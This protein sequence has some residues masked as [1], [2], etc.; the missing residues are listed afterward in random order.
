[1]KKIIF[2]IIL[3]AAGA[4]LKVFSQTLKVTSFKQT[5]D[6]TASR[7]E[8]RDINGIPCGLIKVWLPIT[9]AKFV[10]N[11]VETTYK[12][13]EWW[14]YMTNGSKKITIKSSKHPPLSYEF[15]EPIQ[16]KVTY[17]MAIEILKEVDPLYVDGWSIY[18]NGRRL[19]DNEIRTLFANTPAYEQYE[20]GLGIYESTFWNKDDRWG[21]PTSKGLAYTFLACGGT[22]VILGY[23]FASLADDEKDVE[24][25]KKFGAAGLV[26]TG[27]GCG[28]FLIRTS[29]LASGKAKIR[30]A[31]NLYNNQGM[32]SQSDVKMEYGLT[33]NGVYFSLLF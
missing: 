6:L 2:L 13:G 27:I 33:G 11:V 8:K 18:K 15:T 25:M 1:M 17:T 12:N 21:L 14:V 3:F 32:Y 7:V 29:V 22:M 24:A 23:G 28:I 5:N 20:K 19:G 9:D 31:V 30:K 4:S 16:S 10:G 26:A